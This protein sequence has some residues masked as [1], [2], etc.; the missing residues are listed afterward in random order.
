M[1]SRSIVATQLVSL[2]TLLL[3][4]WIEFE[5]RGRQGRR[6]E[7]GLAP[8]QHRPT[9]RQRAVTRNASLRGRAVQG[10][11]RP[12]Q[13]R[14]ARTLW[15]G[16]PRRRGPPHEGDRVGLRR[17]RLAV[18]ACLCQ[19]WHRRAPGGRGAAHHHELCSREGACH[20][21]GR[22][23]AHGWPEGHRRRRPQPRGR[24]APPAVRLCNPLL[25]PADW[26]GVR[27]RTFD[28]PVQQDTVRA[29]GGIPVDA[30]FNW[31]SQVVAGA[32]RGGEADIAQYAQNGSST[33]VGTITSNVVLWPKV[34]VFALSQKRFDSLT[35]QQRSWVAEAAGWP[36]RLPSTRRTTRPR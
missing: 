7:P 5:R 34:F 35:D 26:A 6:P 24:S 19:R 11:G 30:G 31:Q 29:L 14:A 36:R 16:G 18:G 12:A 8:R 17:R 10:V 15:R 23:R 13:G 21:A 32:L 25:G 9:Q 3:A 28:S 22:R 27:F 2:A 20:L 33:E 1:R 4:A